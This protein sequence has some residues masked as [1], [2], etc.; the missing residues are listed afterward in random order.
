MPN[1]VQLDA[2]FAGAGIAP[3]LSRLGGGEVIVAGRQPVRLLRDSSATFLVR[4]HDGS[5]VSL[6]AP[7]GDAVAEDWLARY[8]GLASPATLR[9]LGEPA[10]TPLPDWVELFLDGLTVRAGSRSSQWPVAAMPFPGGSTLFDVAAKAAAAGDRAFL[11]HLA[12]QWQSL[13]SAMTASRFVHGDLAAGNV[14]WRNNTHLALLNFDQCWWPGLRVARGMPASSAYRHPRLPSG[15]TSADEFALLVILVSLL[16]LAERP[17][18]R[19]HFGDLTSTPGGGILFT[20]A[21]LQEGSDATLFADLGR[22]R[23][24]FFLALVSILREATVAVPGHVPSLHDAVKAARA[25]SPAV[26]LPEQKPQLRA[27]RDDAEQAPAAGAQVEGDAGAGESWRI[28]EA[29]H[30]LKDALASGDDEIVADLWLD[31]RGDDAVSTYAIGAEQALSRLM[32]SEISR[33]IEQGDDQL[34]I[35]SVDGAERLGIAVSFTARRAARAARRRSA[36]RQQLEQAVGAGDSESLAD[37]AS[38][39]DPD[40]IGLRLDDVTRRRVSGNLAIRELRQAVL[41]D[42]D[43]TILAALTR[44][45]HSVERIGLDQSSQQRVELAIARTGW[46]ERIRGAIRSRQAILLAEGMSSIPPGALDRL[47][48]VEQRRIARIVNPPRSGK[49]GPPAAPSPTPHLASARPGAE[50][51]RLLDRLTLATDAVPPDLEQ[52]SRDVPVLR[53]ILDQNGDLHTAANFEVLNNATRLLM[54]HAHRQR[55][56]AAL[57]SGNWRLVAGVAFPDPYGVVSTLPVD[58]QAAVLTALERRAAQLDL[59]PVRYGKT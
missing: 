13:A 6:T 51:H 8:R 45:S 12:E 29:I 30:R 4:D 15:G 33:A 35:E 50:L 1:L 57:Q 14:M 54:V 34:I 55:L 44:V 38:A 3:L 59:Q 5:V 36:G 58:Q 37:L 27:V 31:L 26:V 16:A 7:L 22:S 18:L 9:R 23:D 20:A 28:A 49:P 47:T 53:A 10:A 56:L 42:D 25:V 39:G 2:A 48:Q 41:S 19:Q 40:H 43:A 46:L 52:I 17:G 24:P 11:F 21:D 32:A